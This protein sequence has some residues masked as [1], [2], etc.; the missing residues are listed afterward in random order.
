MDNNKTYLIIER[1]DKGLKLLNES[2]QS[3]DRKYSFGG[4]FTQ[5]E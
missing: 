3:R 4:I 1:A 5:F 2:N